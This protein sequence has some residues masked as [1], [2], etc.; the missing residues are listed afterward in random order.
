VFPGEAEAYPNS[1]APLKGRLLALPTNNRLGW[2]GLSGANNLTHY[3]NSQLTDI[4]KLITCAQ[5]MA[6]GALVICIQRVC[7]TSVISL[8]ILQLYNNDYS[9]IID[10]YFY[11][12]F[13]T[14]TCAQLF[15][16]PVRH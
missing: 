1:G 8:Q 16:H 9:L 13:S 14:L 6:G 4:K 15:K 2:K 5:V 3:K 11:E 12:A 10:I 7:L